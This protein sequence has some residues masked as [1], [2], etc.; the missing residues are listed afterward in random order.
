MRN[1]IAN[2]F[3]LRPFVVMPTINK[4]LDDTDHDHNEEGYDAIV[5]VASIDGEIGREKEEN[6][7]HDHVGDAKLEQYKSTHEFSTGRA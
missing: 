4:P 7:G 2:Q 5:H 3:D 1:R 6:G